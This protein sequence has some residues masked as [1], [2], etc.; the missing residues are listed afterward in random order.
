MA[1]SPNTSSVLIKSVVVNKF[2]V[3]VLSVLLLKQNHEP[4]RMIASS[5]LNLT[6]FEGVAVGCEILQM[7]KYSV[8]NC[9]PFSDKYMLFIV[10]PLTHLVIIVWLSASSLQLDIQQCSEDVTVEK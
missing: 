9:I 1:S 4:D 8:L 7:S 6:S 5:A 2:L 3:R 10:I